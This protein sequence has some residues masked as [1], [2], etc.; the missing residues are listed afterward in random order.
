[1]TKDYYKILGVKEDASG[2]EIR[3]QWIELTKHHH[4]DRA[5]GKASGERIKDIN[6]AY[7]VLKHSSTRVEYDLRRTYDQ[8]KRKGKRGSFFKRF[9][10][11]VSLLIILII[12]SILYFKNSQIP[13]HSKPISLNDIKHINLSNPTK[14]TGPMDSSDLLLQVTQFKPSSLL[15][16]EEDVRR[17]FD[18]YIESYNR[19]DIESLLSLFSLKAIQNQKDGF[20]EI[21]KIYSNFFNEGKEIRY[22]IQ[23]MKI[24][25]YQD[26]A[27]VMAYYEL[28]QLLKMGGEKK[29]WRGQ[30]R[31]VLNKENGVLKIVCLDYQP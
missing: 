17:F 27:E 21:Q 7:Q 20:E 14:P 9:G 19:M 22:R 11:P 25:I 8:K 13:L 26:A 12:L 18:R 4:P 28:E 30:V 16:K 3:A 15:T 29:V 2:E 23:D 5:E 1:M 10:I 24:G 31:W 6:E